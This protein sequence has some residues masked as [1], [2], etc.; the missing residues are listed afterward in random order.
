MRYIDVRT[1]FNLTSYV[2]HDRQFYKRFR[3]VDNFLQFLFLIA[4]LL[5]VAT[6]VYTVFVG[7]SFSAILSLQLGGLSR[8]LGLPQRPALVLLDLL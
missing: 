5:E 6:C 4:G 2:E 7:D 3:T 8:T 1:V